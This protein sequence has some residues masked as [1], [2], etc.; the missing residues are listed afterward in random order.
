MLVEPPLTPETG[1]EIATVAVRLSSVGIADCPQ[2]V[3]CGTLLSGSLVV[4]SNDQHTGAGGPTLTPTP[5]EAGYEWVLHRMPGAIYRCWADADLSMVALTDRIE[6][7]TG[8][9]VEALVANAE[10]SYASL[11][12]PDDRAHVV[13]TMA[14]VRDRGEPRDIEYRLRH[15]QGHELW[16]RHEAWPVGA[17]H[18]DAPGLI[19]GFIFDVT[20][21][22]RMQRADAERQV[23]HA[24][25]QRCL[26]ELATDPA[27]AEGRVDELAHEV[28]E[29]VAALVG[30]ERASVWLLD[31]SGERL[32]LIDLFI[33]S[34]GE[35]RR[36]AVL[37]ARDVP[38]YFQA[39]RTGRSIDAHDALVDPRTREF[40]DSYLRPQGIR[41]ML[42]AAIR[43]AG[44]VAGVVCLE[45]VGDA[46]VWQK[47]EVDFAGEV[48]DQLS[49]ALYSRARL[50]AQAEQE[51]LRAQ[52]FQSQKMDA[53]GRLA[54]GVAHDFNNVLMAISGNAEI[55]HATVDDPIQRRC[56]EEIVD[57]SFRAG[58]LVG[59]LL[60]FARREPL[61]LRTVDLGD[62]V[63]Q[64]EGMLRRLLDKRLR[65]EVQVGGPEFRVRASETLIQ[66][67]LTN[68]VVNARDAVEDGGHIILALDRVDWAEPGEPARPQARVRVIDD[69][70]GMSAEIRAKVFE[71]FFTT[72]QPGEGTGLGLATVYS[73]VRRCGGLV[74]IDSE[75]GRGTTV[76]V[77]LPVVTSA[78]PP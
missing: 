63:R 23:A 10:H 72:K 39:L 38:D 25:Q 47:H 62:V 18:A 6:R 15:R 1:G 42:D 41:S 32:E 3:G 71:P 35:H 58:E 36:D 34:T 13:A 5:S 24:L 30:V 65:F 19:E 2:P 17:D 69:G 45:H 12:H 20:E 27:V 75:V 7:L 28:S 29:R 8:Y 50:A 21:R 4:V 51:E 26:F 9:P 44:K 70:A 33:R 54:G 77:M 56:A 57:A 61:D 16:V 52:L 46:R 67:V 60:R 73:I 74:E 76:T 22:R 49:L 53:L 68:L 43:V 64:L 59:Q 40:A 48:A 37:L 66:Q 55:L 31:G 78:P 11:I 14:M